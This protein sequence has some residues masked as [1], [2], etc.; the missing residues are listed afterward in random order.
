[1]ALASLFLQD[2][3]IEFARSP[4]QLAIQDGC[5]LSGRYRAIATSARFWLPAASVPLE[6]GANSRTRGLSWVVLV[7]P[8][9]VTLSED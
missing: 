7:A 4:F 2:H 5:L 3:G 9:V 6:E 8:A 1:M